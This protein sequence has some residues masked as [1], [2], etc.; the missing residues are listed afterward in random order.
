VIYGIFV[1]IMLSSLAV[2]I[3]GKAAI[4][5]FL[6][7]SKV[8]IS[9]LFPAVLVFCVFGA[10]AVDNKM[11]AVLVMLIMGLGGY[12]MLLFGIPPLSVFVIAR[13]NSKGK[14]KTGRA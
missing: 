13:R 11:F 1:G 5:L 12:F 4:R 10:Y 8:P 2:L 14:K 3:L 6:R 9:V 7:I